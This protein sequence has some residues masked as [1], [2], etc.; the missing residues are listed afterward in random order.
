MGITPFAILRRTVFILYFIN[1]GAFLVLL[2]W[3]IRGIL[4]SMQRRKRFRRRLNFF[5]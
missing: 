4:R 2:V 5:R 3:T 1:I